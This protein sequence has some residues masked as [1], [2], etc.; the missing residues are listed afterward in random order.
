MKNEGVQNSNF[1]L[2]IYKFE[3]IKK[4][5][6]AMDSN[7]LQSLIKNLIK[8]NYKVTRTRKLLSLTQII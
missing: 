1:H 3:N 5:K 4:T 6:N 7:K 8:W 2:A